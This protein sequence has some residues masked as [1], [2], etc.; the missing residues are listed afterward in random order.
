M[1]KTIINDQPHNTDPR[2]AGF[3]IKQKPSSNIEYYGNNEN[4]IFVQFKN[5]G[6]YLYKDVAPDTIKQMHQAESIGRF[7][8]VLSKGNIYVKLGNK[9][10]EPEIKTNAVVD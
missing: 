2:L 5:G 6:A 3:E 10:V 1:L 4:Q 9:L 7:I 8:S